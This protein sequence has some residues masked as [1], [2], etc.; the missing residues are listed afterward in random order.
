M[1]SSLGFCPSLRIVPIFWDAMTV[2]DEGGVGS[3]RETQAVA[4]PLHQTPHHWGL[5]WAQH[6]LSF[7]LP[8]DCVT[9]LQIKETLTK[10]QCREKK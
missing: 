9:D 5:G 3:Q 10:K 7:L 2:I 8:Q 6:T 4:L 1:N